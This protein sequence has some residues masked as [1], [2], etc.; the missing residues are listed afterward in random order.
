MNFIRCTFYYANIPVIYA[1]SA[2]IAIQAHKTV[3]MIRT[4]S[5]QVL[6]SHMA[7]R[8]AGKR[9]ISSMTTVEVLKPFLLLCFCLLCVWFPFFFRFFPFF[10]LI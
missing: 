5:V 7:I 10:V 8:P 6:D 2:Q 1:Y 3:R 9:M 4:G